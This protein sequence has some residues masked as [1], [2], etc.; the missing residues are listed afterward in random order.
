MNYDE[1]HLI[2]AKTMA[3]GDTD[4]FT[5]SPAHSVQASTSFQIFN[6]TQIVIIQGH[7][8]FWIYVFKVPTEAFT[9]Q[10]IPQLDSL[11]NITDSYAPRTCGH[12]PMMYQNCLL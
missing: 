1:T 8:R 12:E 5:G 10:L 6:I 11:G 2:A 3:V 4:I 9:A 7:R